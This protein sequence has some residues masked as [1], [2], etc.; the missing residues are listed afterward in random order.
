MSDPIAKRIRFDR[1]LAESSAFLHFDPRRAGVLVPPFLRARPQVVLQFSHRFPNPMRE[2]VVTDESVSAVL[3]FAR[4]PFHVVVPWSAV[5]AVVTGDADVALWIDDTPAEL[6][7]SRE[8]G[9]AS[10]RSSAN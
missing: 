9:A 8:P 6:L 7:P 2:F 5:F 1:A 3:S 10:R 4:I